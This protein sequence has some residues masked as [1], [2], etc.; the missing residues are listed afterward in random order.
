MLKTIGEI[1]KS[2]GVTVG[3]VRAWDRAGKIKSVRTPGGHRRYETMINPN[4]NLYD[5]VNDRLLPMT[6]AERKT[7]DIIR[8]SGMDVESLA[9]EMILHKRNVP[10]FDWLGD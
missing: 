6:K 1:A 8:A 10:E 7:L 5:I 4:Y 2:H 3:T 9:K